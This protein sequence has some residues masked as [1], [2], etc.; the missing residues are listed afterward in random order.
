MINQQWFK[1]IVGDARNSALQYASSVAGRLGR[2]CLDRKY[3]LSRLDNLGCTSDSHDLFFLGSSASKVSIEI[4]NSGVVRLDHMDCLDL[5]YGARGALRGWSGRRTSIGHAAALWSHHWMGYYHWLI[6][7]APKIAAIQKSAGDQV[8]DLRWIYPRCGEA[9]ESEILE[10]LDLPDSHIIDS[11]TY[12]SIQVESVAM[13]AL[14]G[15]FEIQ[16]AAALL[17]ERLLPFGHAGVGD[18]IY[19]KR[20]GRRICAFFQAGVLSWWR[21][22]PAVLPIK[23]ACSGMQRSS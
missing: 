20:R 7:V 17:R 14:P 16:P 21:T 23:S 22:F 15:W 3:T 6:D 2:R 8:H 11:R 12:R 5:D 9:Y 18:R 4:L 19:L 1:R 13:V 10:M